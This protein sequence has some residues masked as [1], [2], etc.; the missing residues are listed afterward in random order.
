MLLS[1]ILLGVFTPPVQAPVD[2]VAVYS[3]ILSEVRT[4]RPGLPIVLGDSRSGVA[5][6]PHCPANFREGVLADQ[7][8]HRDGPTTHSPEVLSALLKRGLIEAWCKTPDATLGCHGHPGHMF[9]GLGTIS[10]APSRGPPPEQDGLWVRVAFLLPGSCD[11]VEEEA[12]CFPDAF[13]FWYLMTEED[14]AWSVKRRWPAFA[15]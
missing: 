2:S 8:E 10:A 12:A 15:V 4:H 7:Q 1:V 13:G 9:I 14:G 5:C 3:A 6:M 11:H